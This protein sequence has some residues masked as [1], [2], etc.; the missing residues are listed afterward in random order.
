[1][2]FDGVAAGAVVVVM[3]TSGFGAETAGFGRDGV[4]LEIGPPYPGTVC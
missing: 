1:V 4:G 2:G 3:G